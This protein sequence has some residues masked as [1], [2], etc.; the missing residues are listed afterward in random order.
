MCQRPSRGSVGSVATNP[1]S[2]SN[3]PARWQG[4][5]HGADTQ[6]VATATNHDDRRR[7]LTRHTADGTGHPAGAGRGQGLGEAAGI[8]EGKH[9]E[10]GTD[11]A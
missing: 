9:L 8:V 5:H 3:A 11:H 1:I 7:I 4:F 2:E 6:M 10:I